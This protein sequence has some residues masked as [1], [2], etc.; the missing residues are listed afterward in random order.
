MRASQRSSGSQSPL[1]SSLDRS[2]RPFVFFNSSLLAQILP[3]SS[4][5]ED[6]TVRSG[7]AGGLVS[8]VRIF[9]AELWLGTGAIDTTEKKVGSRGA[10]SQDH[11]RTIVRIQ[12][13]GQEQDLCDPSL[14]FSLA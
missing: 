8:R 10:G 7:Y 13:K 5:S 12:E 3:S 6:E 9:Q 14:R 4:N 11:R 2:N 1:A